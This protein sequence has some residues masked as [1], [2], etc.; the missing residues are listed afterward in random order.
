MSPID[1]QRVINLELA[2]F[3]EV[4]NS[5]H[6]GKPYRNQNDSKEPPKYP[7]IPCS[8]SREIAPLTKNKEIVLNIPFLRHLS[9]YS[10]L[11]IDK[12]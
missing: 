3:I 1:S 12:K 5:R 9:G 4:S 11:Q 6:R 8:L 2:N 7:T 10:P